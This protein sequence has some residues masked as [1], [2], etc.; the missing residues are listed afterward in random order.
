MKTAGFIVLLLTLA[1]LSLSLSPLDGGCN[2]NGGSCQ[3]GGGGDNGRRK[4]TLSR[5]WGDETDNKV[6]VRSL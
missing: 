4:I 3:C 2:G 6:L 1:D 5:F